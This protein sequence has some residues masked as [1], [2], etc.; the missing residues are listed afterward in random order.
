MLHSKSGELALGAPVLWTIQ[1]LPAIRRFRNK[2]Q[3]NP[4]R[5]IPVPIMLVH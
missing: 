4:H 5:R 3:I 2:N 1:V